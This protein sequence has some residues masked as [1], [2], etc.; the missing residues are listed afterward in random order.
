[1]NYDSFLK[2]KAISA[3]ISGFDV[4]LDE[5]SDILKPHQKLAVQWAVKG[6]RRALFEAFG[7][8]KTA[9]QLEYCR[10]VTKHTGGRALLVLPLG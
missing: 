7:L 10:L 9:Q 3:P 1:M 5:I 8:G 2:N 4:S 6:G